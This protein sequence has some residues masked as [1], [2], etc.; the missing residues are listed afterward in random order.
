[1]RTVLLA[2]HA[3]HAE[4]GRVLSGR[5]DI[6]LSEAGCAEADALAE[7]L[8][9][10]PMA[11]LHVSPRVRARQT[12]APVAAARGLTA[13]IAP[14]LDEI[15]FG[16]FTGQSFA[17]LDARDP[18][19]LAWNAHRSTARCPGGETMAEAVGRARDYL[20]GLPAE[21]F[22]A[23]CVSHCDVIRGLVADG[24]GLPL[25]RLFAFDC[26]PASL[27]TLT[28]SDAGMRVVALN[29]RARQSA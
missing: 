1:M 22:P 23:L 28:W 16:R 29:Q 20:E 21:A 17:A 8:E 11:S 13:R 5:S 14:A 4:V 9:G 12:A 25:D 7:M 15:D 6:A 3:S 2:R 18:D 19:W 27:T 10:T 26:D 24:L